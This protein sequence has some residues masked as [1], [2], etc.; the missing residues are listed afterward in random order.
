MVLLVEHANAHLYFFGFV[1]RDQYHY[2]PVGWNV[3][4]DSVVAI[5]SPHL[6]AGYAV[7]ILD[8]AIDVSTLYEL[9]V[10]VVLVFPTDIRPD[11]V[12]VPVHIILELLPLALQRAVLI[13]YF[14]IIAIKIWLPV[15]LIAFIQV[16]IFP[17]NFLLA[18]LL[19]LISLLFMQLMIIWL[20]VL[21]IFEPLLITII[22]SCA[23]NAHDA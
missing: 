13:R 6:I 14:Q 5:Q 11:F 2:R 8:V 18:G 20:L 4:Q 23:L 16:L 12:L 15:I 7:Q 17:L 10:D 3:L 21:Y 1:L 19:L 22:L 9:L